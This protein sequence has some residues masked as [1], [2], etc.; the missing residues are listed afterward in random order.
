VLD[1]GFQ[2]TSR[3]VMESNRLSRWVKNVGKRGLFQVANFGMSVPCPKKKREVGWG[4]SDGRQC[5]R[6]HLGA[7]HTGKRVANGSTLQKEKEEKEEEGCDL[8]LAFFYS[9]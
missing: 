9:A 1:L 3:S 4:S 5:G 8:T 6:F 2:C 7:D